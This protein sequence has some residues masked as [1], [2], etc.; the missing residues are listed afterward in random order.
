MQPSSKAHGSSGD[1]FV[2]GGVGASL[3]TELS[4]LPHGLF[5]AVQTQLLQSGRLGC[6][7]YCFTYINTGKKSPGEPAER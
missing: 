7:E 4:C 2:L 6:T 5:G 3:C 1:P